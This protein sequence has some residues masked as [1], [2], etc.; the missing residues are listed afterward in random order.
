VLGC[1]PRNQDTLLVLMDHEEEFDKTGIKDTPSHVF[2]LN[3]RYRQQEPHS[4]SAV[5]H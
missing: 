5:S 1:R 3:E 2:D 4:R